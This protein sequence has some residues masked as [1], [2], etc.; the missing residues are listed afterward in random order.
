MPAGG[1]RDGVGQRHRMASRRRGHGDGV[2][3]QRPRGL[4]VREL[5]APVGLSGRV[6]HGLS[7]DDEATVPMNGLTV[8]QILSQALRGREDPRGDRRRGLLGTRVV[9][10]AKA[11][12]LT[13]IPDAAPAHE[14]LLR[15]LRPDHMMPCGC[16]LTALCSRPMEGNRT[17]LPE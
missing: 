4:Y 9:Q 11:A 3:A 12:R 1:G 15:S 6:P 14:A 2:T 10:L 16:S 8:L 13:S 5:E 7:I 17:A